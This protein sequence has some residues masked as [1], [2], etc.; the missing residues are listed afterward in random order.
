M[1]RSDFVEP[2]QVG[3]VLDVVDDVV[4]RLGE[5][6]DVLAVERGDVLGVQELDDLP[7]QV[8]AV[9]LELL[10]VGLADVV[11]GIGLGTGASALRAVASTFSPRC[12]QVVELGGCGTSA[13][14]MRAEPNALCGRLLLIV[15]VRGVRE[16]TEL[17]R[18]EVRGLLADVDCVVADPLEAAGDDDHPE[19]P[20][21]ELG[22]V[23]E[24]EHV[25]HDAP[26]RAVDQ[27]VQVDEALGAG[28]V[29]FREGVSATRIIS[30]AR[31][32]ISSK[33]ST[34]ISSGFSS[35][36]ELRQLGDRHAEVGHPLEVE[37]ECSTAS[38]SRRSPA[39]GVWR[40][41]SCSIP[42]PIAR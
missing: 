25:L 3:G 37:V 35:A 2:E 32:P 17:A 11:L 28:D 26:V 39:T 15:R 24:L 1:A 33:P 36:R 10:D 30:S 38:T 4:D 18:D 5:L 14:F 42:C 23:A 9:V 34:S 16:L 20:L 21:A 19:P 27:L 6:V 7:G 12:E 40:A 22:V 31:R 8:V 13:S 41:S 29:A